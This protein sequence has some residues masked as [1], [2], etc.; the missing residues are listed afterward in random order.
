MMSNNYTKG[1]GGGEDGEAKCRMVG[2]VYCNLY[3]SWMW[4]D[5]SICLST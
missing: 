3:K 1:A 5:T 2:R 4:I